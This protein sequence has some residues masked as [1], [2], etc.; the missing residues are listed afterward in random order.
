MRPRLKNAAQIQ[1]RQTKHE[2]SKERAEKDAEVIYEERGK[3]KRRRKP[4][5]MEK[6]QDKKKEEDERRKRNRSFRKRKA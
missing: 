3:T 2:I 6:E 1:T 5:S 4:R